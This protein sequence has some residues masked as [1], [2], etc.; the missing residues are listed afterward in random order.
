[1]KDTIVTEEHYRLDTLNLANEA[2]K[3]LLEK[4]WNLRFKFPEVFWSETILVTGGLDA[5]VQFAQN[6]ASRLWLKLLDE[7]T[8][9]R[10][11]IAQFCAGVLPM[12]EECTDQSLTNH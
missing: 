5:L 8:G 11:T 1:M 4:N 3:L 9:K 6:E 10:C 2:G 12:L 7:R